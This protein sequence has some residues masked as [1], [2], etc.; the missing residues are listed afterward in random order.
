VPR[1]NWDIIAPNIA[2]A[3][4]QL[5]EIE[6]RLMGGDPP[7]PVEFQM[8]MQHAFHHLNF[9]WNA[10]HWPTSRY[11]SLTE[12]DFRVAGG[13]PTDLDFDDRTGRP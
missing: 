12:A 5:E 10:R 9:A 2:E 1:L 7:E 8:M 4:E 11:G 3:R 6:A 13:Q